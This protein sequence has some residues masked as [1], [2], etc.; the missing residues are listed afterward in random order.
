MEVLNQRTNQ[1]I[2]G[3]MVTMDSF[4]KR[5]RGYMFQPRPHEGSGL[6]FPGVRRVHTFGMKF[7]IDVMF[8]D[9]SMCVT[10]V[11]A[12]VA[13]GRIPPSPP[14]TRHIM[15]MPSAANAISERVRIG[16]RLTLRMEI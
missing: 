13:G 6:F 12:G 14:G 4:W 11:A 9:G 10:G 16:D 3:D 5:L 15:E 8:L 2:V 1:V 7:P